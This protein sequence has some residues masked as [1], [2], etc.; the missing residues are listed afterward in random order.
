MRLILLPALRVVALLALRLALAALL[1]PSLR[2]PVR[3]PSLRLA[4]RLPSL[5]LTV[6]AL[7]L[8]SLRLP[9]RLLALRLATVLLTLLLAALRL[10]TLRLTALLLPSLRLAAV[11]LP[12]RDLRDL[13]V[14][15][16]SLRL[17]LRRREPP[18]LGLA[19]PGLRL[20]ARLNLAA[21]PRL[22]RSRTSLRLPRRSLP[23]RAG[24]NLSVPV[25]RLPDSSRRL[26]HLRLS[27]LGL[28]HL[29]L[30][31]HLLPRPTRTLRLPRPTRTL[32][33]PRPTR[34]L[35]LPRRA[36][37]LRLPNV[38]LPRHPG[39]PLRHPTHRL[40]PVLARRNLPLRPPRRRET[41]RHPA[42]RRALLRPPLR[43]LRP[44]RLPRLRSEP[45]TGRVRTLPLRRPVNPP[46]RRGDR[47]RRHIARR[48][49][50]QLVP[51]LAV[52]V[53][54]DGPVGE[55]GVQTAQLVLP[56]HPGAPRSTCARWTS[57]RR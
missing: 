48:G 41:L 28:P 18:T 45:R 20:G 37:S 13:R 11:R 44:R 25:L 34:T 7:L 47:S 14:P 5:R 19:L 30:N 53:L 24:L 38:R 10:A 9:A 56:T 52:L 23:R 31:P 40:L 54:G 49:G 6:A 36:R 1:L 12:L 39:G 55:L 51:H 42:L 29:R 43:R 57:P 50:E 22:D 15:G 8:V 35:R 33:L 26:P 21:L 17:L 32:R 4:Q 3:L 2:L 16:F 27:I 46:P